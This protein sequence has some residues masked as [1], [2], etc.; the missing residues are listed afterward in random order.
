MSQRRKS[1]PLGVK[2]FRDNVHGYIQIPN[3]IVREIIDTEVFQRLRHIEQTSMRPLYPA[4]RHDR[5]I[6]SLGVYHLGCRAFDAL[7][8]TAPAEV[9]KTTKETERQRWWNRWR[10]L[11]TLACLLHDCAHA[12]FSHTLEKYYDP[13]LNNKSIK[14]N[15]STE[16][17]SANKADTSFSSDGKK[18]NSLVGAPH[19]RMS[20]LVVFK[21][22]REPLERIFAVYKD[23]HE[24]DGGLTE[25]DLSFMARA[26]IGCRYQSDDSDA[27]F[28]NCLISLLNSSTLFDVDGLDYAVRDT[29]NS[30]LANWSVDYDRLFRGLR[31]K[32]GCLLPQDSQIISSTQQAVWTSNSTF[33]NTEYED[34]SKLVIHGAF[35]VSFEDAGVEKK[36]YQRWLERNGAAAIKEIP[37]KEGTECLKI[38]VVR[39]DA[40][41]E[42]EPASYT[43][44]LARSCKVETH[45]WTGKVSG[46]I[47]TSK[48][49]DGCR[50]S[51]DNPSKP[52]YYLAFDKNA[53]SSITGA[54]EARNTFYRWVFS[55][56]MV[57]YY[58]TFLQ[59]YLFKLSAKYLCCQYHSQYS[60]M[61][62]H[63]PPNHCSGSS[64]LLRDSQ[65]D[66]GQMP[67]DEDQ[68]S[69]DEKPKPISEEDFAIELLGIDGFL[70]H[71]ESASEVASL[72]GIPVACTTDDDLNALFK[73]V[74]LDNKLR[75]D[76]ANPEIER[77]FGEYFSRP[78]KTSI[79]KSYE[80]WEHMS[81]ADSEWPHFEKNKPQG[82][83]T[84]L[85][86]LDFVFLDYDS[87][88]ENTQSIIKYFDPNRN[89]SLLLIRV[90]AKTKEMNVESVYITFEKGVE[91]LVD[92][93]GGIPG[94]PWSKNFYY[95]YG[96][97]ATE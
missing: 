37:A 55:H 68:A 90:S 18:G 86:S 60:D 76:D 23:C 24:I 20:A 69:E 82:L 5:F 71:D 45:H 78:K 84:S 13:K 93:M 79:W 62:P 48:Q 1:S 75:G 87:E 26:I 53:I 91:R 94:P 92:V 19:E 15:L 40:C 31:L 42:L 70:G 61:P 57:Q 27:S 22:F 10:L 35:E 65:P 77:Y 2:V 85:A 17:I 63:C 73:W 81:Q 64:C 66:R 80:E 88:D 67:E 56:P 89:R 44:V 97:V 41:C 47:L 30:G 38:K 8:E 34:G 11:F 51:S 58:S 83:E 4:A 32:Q 3:I 36:C 7:R 28:K 49:P 21:Y 16:L 50:A 95:L 39:D 9:A 43:V 59:N 74:Y 46:T 6:H 96:D 25:T 52:C 14:W 72:I 54:L 33:S 29:Y 12:P